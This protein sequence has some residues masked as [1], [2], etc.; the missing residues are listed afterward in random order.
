MLDFFQSL[1]LKALLVGLLVLYVFV[2]GY[3][4]GQRKVQDAFDKFKSAQ[5]VQLTEALRQVRKSDL[6]AAL[7]TQSLEGEYHEAKSNLDRKSVELRRLVAE[8]GGL[9]DPGAVGSSCV[10]HA[11]HA[12]GNSATGGDQ[13]RLSRQANEFLLA[14]A[15]RGDACAARDIAGSGYARVMDKWIKEHSK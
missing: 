7:Q 9:R 10:S 4:L 1:W 14:E 13:G 11:P 2:K 12:A 8:R 15:Q 6:A 5:Q 3:G